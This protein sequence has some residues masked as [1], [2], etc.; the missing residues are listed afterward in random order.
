[1]LL[2]PFRDQRDEVMR[3]TEQ[4]RIEG[5]AKEVRRAAGGTGDVR[6]DDVRTGD[7][8]RTEGHIWTFGPHVKLRAFSVEGEHG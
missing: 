8:R 5:K 4:E 7:S 6:L 3:A 2:T 1:M